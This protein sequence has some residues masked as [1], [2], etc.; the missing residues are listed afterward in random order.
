MSVARLENVIEV[1]TVYSHQPQA[2][3]FTFQYLSTSMY[4]LSALAMLTCLFDR[5]EPGILQS[6]NALRGSTGSQDLS[7]STAWHEFSAISLTSAADKLVAEGSA[8]GCHK[9]GC[10]TPFS[11]FASPWEQFVVAL[12]LQQHPSFGRSKPSLCTH[13][14]Q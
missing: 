10:W 8:C 2:S 9:A 13:N 11:P 3:I 14:L 12:Q 6:R 4:M 7:V 1:A 5:G